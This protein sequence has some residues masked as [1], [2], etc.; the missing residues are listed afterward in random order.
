M[1]TEGGVFRIFRRG[2]GYKRDTYRRRVILAYRGRCDLLFKI[3][4]KISYKLQ[5]IC[6]FSNVLLGLDII[7]TNC[8]EIFFIVLKKMLQVR[9]FFDI[10]LMFDCREN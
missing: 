4:G 1:D 2:A 10:S 7:L 3:I 8:F 9:R 5:V 6:L